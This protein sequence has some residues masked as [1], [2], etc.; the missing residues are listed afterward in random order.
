MQTYGRCRVRVI[1]HYIL[2]TKKVNHC[3]LVSLNDVNNQ[4]YNPERSIMEA[5]ELNNNVTCRAT[6]YKTSQEYM[7]N[8]LKRKSYIQYN[9]KILAGVPRYNNFVV[10]ECD[11][12]YI[13]NIDT[14]NS[15][16]ITFAKLKPN[17]I[18]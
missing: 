17:F 16:S 18:R 15:L 14:I 3:R 9:N 1:M 10:V 12:T 6:I 2:T 7:A 13:N 5:C 11:N 8:T 4:L